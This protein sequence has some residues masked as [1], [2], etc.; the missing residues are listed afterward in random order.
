MIQFISQPWPWWVAGILI[1]LT[2]VSLLILGKSFGVSSTFRT[3]CSAS[4]MGKNV[5][6]F[7]YDWKKDIWNLVF[8]FGTLL[9]GVIAHRFLSPAE[10]IALS[11]ATLQDLQA[12]GVSTD[13]TT[14][15]PMDLFSWD[16]LWTPKGFI[17]IIIG[18]FL[19]GFGTRYAGGCTSGHAISGL[20]N[21]Q[22]PSLIAMIGFFI[23]GL[24]CTHLL[25]P[26]ILSL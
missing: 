25:L 13:T 19:V 22:L 17:L 11:D 14:L 10:G 15:A 9:G 12:L 26:L 6:F 18:G 24:I 3:L 7:Q 5:P 1:T 2:M 21:L 8:A 23:G 20:S 4:Q 16:A